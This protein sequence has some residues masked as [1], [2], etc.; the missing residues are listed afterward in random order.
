MNHHSEERPVHDSHNEKPNVTLVWGREGKAVE[1]FTWLAL[2]FINSCSWACGSISPACFSLSYLGFC[3]RHDLFL[4]VP[5][6][7]VA[8]LCQASLRLL[9]CPASCH[10][11]PRSVARLV[12]RVSPCK[13]A[14]CF[15]LTFMFI[16]GVGWNNCELYFPLCGIKQ[17]LM[18]LIIEI[19]QR[20]STIFLSWNNKVNSTASWELNLSRGLGSGL[21]QERN[22]T[23]KIAL[24]FQRCPGL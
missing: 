15:S 9:H 18:L 2:F 20:V 17:R 24:P 4:W 3:W 16:P 8:W 13:G 19:I 12:C 6:D 14:A 11:S 22:I 5:Q 23:K 1:S 7:R 21:P 10:S